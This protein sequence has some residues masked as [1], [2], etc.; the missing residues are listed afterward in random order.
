MKTI[1]HVSLATLLLTISGLA[2][3]NEGWRMNVLFDNQSSPRETI[4]TFPSK[5]IAGSGYPPAVALMGLV[6]KSKKLA[7]HFDWQARVGYRS[8]T[9]LTIIWDNTPPENHL[10]TINEGGTTTV[11]DNPQALLGKLRSSNQLTVQLQPAN[12]AA[13]IT[14]VFDLKDIGVML[15][16]MKQMSNCPELTMPVLA[17]AYPR[18]VAPSPYI[19]QQQSIP[20]QPMPHQSRP[21]IGSSPQPSP[22]GQVAYAPYLSKKEQKQ[23]SKAIKQGIK[24][25]E[26]LQKIQMKG[27]QKGQLAPFEQLALSNPMHALL[28]ART[29]A[30]DGNPD[31]K[32]FL[33][34]ATFN[35]TGIPQNYS[36]AGT[37]YCDLVIN[38]RYLSTKGKIYLQLVENRLNSL[39]L[40]FM[41]KAR[42]P[43]GVNQN[44][45][46]ENANKFRNC[47]ARL[48]F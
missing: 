4:I 11:A 31:A 26:K 13:R 7:L 25:E 22:S 12:A 36:N 3:A 47:L 43:S 33:A 8:Q 1:Y 18:H 40:I 24:M 19:T 15:N 48:R 6:C 32:F 29:L 34:N 44:K 10:F 5:Q 14:A 35:G 20:R 45:E 41:N 30:K 42:N 46:A 17:P 38:V 27:M 37:L 39:T 9:S 2:S 21:K 28:K 23:L 16:R